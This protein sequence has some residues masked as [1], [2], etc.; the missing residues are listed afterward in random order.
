MHHILELS[1]S[2]QMIWHSLYDICMSC[3]ARDV[4]AFIEVIESCL[5]ALHAIM[6]VCADCR[7][8][9]CVLARV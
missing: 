6:T 3:A 7:I 4:P 1:D 9:V 8:P 5:T 2:Y